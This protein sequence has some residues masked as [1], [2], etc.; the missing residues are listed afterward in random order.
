MLGM[1]FWNKLFSGD[2]EIDEESIKDVELSVDELKDQV[3][4]SLK[5]VN[6]LG[7]KNYTM[8]VINVLSRIKSVIK[9]LMSRQLNND[10]NKAL[11]IGANNARK[12]VHDQLMPLLDVKEPADLVGVNSFIK[13]VDK[14]LVR[15]HE[16]SGQSNHAKVIFR[17]DMNNLGNSFEDLSDELDVLKQAIVERN[18]Q[19]EIFNKLVKELRSFGE[20]NDKLG[21]IKK[22]EFSVRKKISSFERDKAFLS[23]EVSRIKS[24]ETFNELNKAEASLKDIDKRKAELE[25]LV[26]NIVSKFSRVLRKTF[27]NDDFVSV[28][29]TN[30]LGFIYK[31]E[32]EFNK[33]MSKLINEINSE[34]LKLNEKD[35]KRYLKAITNDKINDYIIVYKELFRKEK[36]YK[37]GDFTLLRRADAFERR[38]IELNKQV[39]NDVKGLDSFKDRIDSQKREIDALKAK[40]EAM[41]S[42]CYSENVR[43]V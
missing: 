43:L 1:G 15:A 18:E 33:R 29:L 7:D 9:A 40:V 28:F 3:N 20:A 27:R 22:E 30:P 8:S 25:G 5:R 31:D 42:E 35:K 21:G 12:R 39:N 2:E 10:Y 38:L 19:L 24:I 16:V 41:A 32:G 6:N 13:A 26:M 36:L 11:L 14:L 23:S 17:D 34:A 37:K 4:S